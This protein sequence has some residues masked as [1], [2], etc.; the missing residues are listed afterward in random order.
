M[1][2]FLALVSVILVNMLRFNIYGGKLRD[3]TDM[4]DTGIYKSITLFNRST[5]H[6]SLKV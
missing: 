3:V 5:M 6:L 4:A 1:T 2:S